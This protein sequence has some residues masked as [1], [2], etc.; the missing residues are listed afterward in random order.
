MDSST[1]DGPTAHGPTAGGLPPCP[2][3]GTREDR[4]A[5]FRPP[6]RRAISR[7]LTR[8]SWVL[9]HRWAGITLTLFLAVAGV[10][11]IFLTWIEELEVATAPELHLAAPP[12]PG[13]KP[14]DPLELRRQVLARYPA[15]EIGYLPLEL[16]PGRSFRVHVHWHDPKTGKELADAPAWDDLFLDPYTGRELGRR[17]WGNIGQGVKNLMPFLYRLHYQ[18]ALGSWGQLAFGIAALVW[19]IDCFVGF[20]LTLPVRQR[21]LPGPAA[22]ASSPGWW[23]RWRPSW[24]VRWRAS[25]YKLN[26]DLH[27]AGGLWLWPLLLVFAWSAVSFNLPQVYVPLMQQFGADDPRDKYMQALLPAPRERPAI[28]FDAALAQGERLAAAETAKAGLTL[29]ADGER[30]LW[31]APEI[32]AYVYGFTSSADFTAHGGGTS[33]AFDSD[34]GA[35]RDFAVPAGRNGANTFGNWLAALHMGQVLG[36][37]WR[38][39]V[40]VLGALVTMLSVTGIVIWLRKRSGRAGRRLR[41]AG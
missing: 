3:G 9:L 12:Y 17:E 6:L 22:A 31:H 18:F 11:G 7:P 41:R 14:L 1:L 29:R 20:Y 33:V 25:R 35:L 34:S 8:Q 10:T 13:A 36:L 30:Y 24:A 37:P 21:R 27:R 19:T 23:R 4:A 16:E 5:E 38:I 28:G 32:G 39:A 15:G 40:S 26:F 2:Q